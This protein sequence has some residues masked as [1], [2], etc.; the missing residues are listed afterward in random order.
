[1][2]ELKFYFTSLTYNTVQWEYQIYQ[3]PEEK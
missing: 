1:M 3:K 2:L